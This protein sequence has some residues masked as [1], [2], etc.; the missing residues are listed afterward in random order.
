ML[1][2]IIVRI[3]GFCIR[4]A[5]TVVGIGLLIAV[6]SSVYTASHFRLNSDV[7]ALL[8]DKLDWRKRALAFESA[9]GRFGMIDVVVA[10]PT[11]ELTGAATVESTQA[12]AKE[13]ALFPDAR[14]PAPRSFSPS[15]G[16]CSCRS[17]RWRGVS[18]SDS[19]RSA[20]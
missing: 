15:T 17:R 5:W 19:G 9:F 12:L 4:H 2:S 8:S 3:V 6:G 14:T 11:P 10:A 13:K 18:G 20:D 7:S 16:F 1:T